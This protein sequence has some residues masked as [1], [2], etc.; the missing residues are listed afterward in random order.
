MVI[1]PQGSAWWPKVVSS[2]GTYYYMHGDAMARLCSALLVLAF[3]TLSDTAHAD[4]LFAQWGQSPEET[5][6]HAKKNGIILE[7]LPKLG[8]RKDNSMWGI[9]EYKINNIVMS[10]DFNYGDISESLESILMCAK[11]IHNPSLDF[12]GMR[13]AL[14]TSLGN[15]KGT[16][17]AENILV[18]LWL[19]AARNN[20]IGAT[21]EKHP[22]EGADAMVGCVSYTPL[23]KARGF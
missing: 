7:K 22:A 20:Q 21:L 3:L 2:M 6:N 14:E 12:S 19:D 17:D 10:V 11:T 23:A 1:C 4:W 8:T 9:E 5:Y 13:L 15:P 16:H 18:L